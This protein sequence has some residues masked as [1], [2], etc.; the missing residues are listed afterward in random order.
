MIDLLGTR[1]EYCMFVKSLSL[2]SKDYNYKV[3]FNVRPKAMFSSHGT[4]LF[5]VQ[6][7]EEGGWVELVSTKV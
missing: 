4:T 3:I 2:N 5:Y 6:R 1:K 7:S